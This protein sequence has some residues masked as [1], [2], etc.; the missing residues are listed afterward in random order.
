MLAPLNEDELE[1][2]LSEATDTLRDALAEL[3]SDSIVRGAGGKVG[4]SLWRLARRAASDS[5]R[6]IVVIRFT[7]G[8]V[9]E[10]LS[11][12]DIEVICGDPLDRG[13]RCSPSSRSAGRVH[14][15]NGDKPTHVEVRAGR[16]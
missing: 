7:V 12:R 2:K 5:R 14:D 3:E 13:P 11:D 8:H 1:T 10:R 6:I 16:F 15:R 9:I 4:P